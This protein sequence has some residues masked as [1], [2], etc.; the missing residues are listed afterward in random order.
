MIA[1]RLRAVL[2]LL[3]AL[4]AAACSDATAPIPSADQ[5]PGVFFVEMQNDTP[6]PWTASA[7]TGGCAALT[8]YGG[9]V[10]F[11]ADGTAHGALRVWG[12]RCP[13]PNGSSLYFDGRD[14]FGTYQV[15]RAGLTVQT[16]YAQDTGTVSNDGLRK[17][18]TVDLTAQGVRM[19]LRRESDPAEAVRQI[20]AMSAF[21][22]P[23]R[24]AAGSALFNVQ[25]GPAGPYVV[26]DGYV[27]LAGDGSAYWVL[28]IG[29][30]TADT[31]TI[32]FG[33]T[34]TASGSQ[35]AVSYA[36][37]DP[38]GTVQLDGSSP[39][40]AT[41]AQFN[42]PFEW[43]GSPVDTLHLVLRRETDA[44]SA[45]ERVWRLQHPGWPWSIN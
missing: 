20:N 27:L 44:T 43:N 11:S 36:G 10:V 9:Y 17:S 33:G 34:Y 18:T 15:H 7:P 1:P 21:P 37:G 2:P 24:R 39:S 16:R 41:T 13:I 30:S 25:P 12:Y 4:V 45:A 31:A 35:L 29:H 5:G 38:A 8:K 26:F 23:V 14:Y 6:I 3:G 42:M 40:R 32:P 19:R 28:M 22:G